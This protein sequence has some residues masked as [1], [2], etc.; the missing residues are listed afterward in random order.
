ML[1]L[2]ML[3]SMEILVSAQNFVSVILSVSVIVIA[4]V[5][6]FFMLAWLL[7]SLLAVPFWYLWSDAEQVDEYKENGL[8]NMHKIIHH[9]KFE[10]ERKIFQN[11]ISEA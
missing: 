10:K 2:S 5:A 6:K 3:F 4:D 1:P 11:V 8:I 7:M 9:F